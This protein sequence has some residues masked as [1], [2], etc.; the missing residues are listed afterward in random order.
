MGYLVWKD[1]VR[2]WLIGHYGYPIRGANKKGS[3]I[4]SVG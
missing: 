4:F 1:A 3:I 2:A